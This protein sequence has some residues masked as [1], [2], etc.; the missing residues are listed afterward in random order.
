MHEIAVIRKIQGTRS[1]FI[2]IARKMLP[3]T[4]ETRFTVTVVNPRKYWLEELHDAYGHLVKSIGKSHIYNSIKIVINKELIQS[5][6][7]SPSNSE[8]FVWLRILPFTETPPP[9]P[10]QPYI[11]RLT[12][13]HFD[14][15]SLFFIVSKRQIDLL[16]EFTPPKYRGSNLYISVLLSGRT[17][18][19]IKKPIL[20]AKR[21]YYKVVLPSELFKDRIKPG[22]VVIIKIFVT[23]KSEELYYV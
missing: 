22:D 8:K 20:V 21:S 9:P 6:G 12:K 1:H 13:V 14:G 15:S 19:Y 18:D 11:A 17:I 16:S 5:L 10:S 4:L 2:T 3:A 7:L 23:N